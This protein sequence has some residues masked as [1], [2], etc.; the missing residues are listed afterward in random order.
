MNQH[1]PPC[2]DEV[3][4]RALLIGVRNYPK[5][6]S[7]WGSDLAGCHNDVAN[8]RRVLLHRGFDDAH[9]RVLIDPIEGCDCPFCDGT[10]PRDEALPTRQG[11]LQAVD[12]L[13]NTCR[14]DDVVVL[15]YSGHGSEITGRRLQ[16]GRRFQSLVPHDSGRGKAPNRDI[17]DGEVQSWLRRLRGKTPHATMIFDCCHSGGL[18]NVRSGSV[19]VRQVLADDRTDDSAYDADVLRQLASSDASPVS[20][21]S[22]GHRGGDAPEVQPGGIVLSASAAHELSS[23][24]SSGGRQFGL[25]TH[26]LCQAL[27]EHAAGQSGDGDDGRRNQPC[28]G[29]DDGPG[30]SV[31]V[32]AVHLSFL[33]FDRAFPGCWR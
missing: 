3:T 18:S 25:F 17:S 14:D 33:L 32:L 24:T 23:E 31:V 22:G 6:P 13:V 20:P 8:L 5:I 30:D 11:I 9:V 28:D 2:S 4:R 19:G 1:Q 27:D 29:H 15:Y 16:A 21:L 12:G 7:D 26:R 10:A